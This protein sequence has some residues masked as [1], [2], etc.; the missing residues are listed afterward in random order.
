MAI[1]PD[2]KDWTWV[3]ERPCTECGFD[4]RVV[5]RES[6]PE[7]IRD[8]AAAWQ[9]LLLGSAGADLRR[10]PSDSRWSRLEY[11]CHVRDVFRLFDRRLR[12][13]LESDEPTFPNWDQDAT[14]VADSYREQDPVD[15][16]GALLDAAEILAGDF[17][18]VPAAAWHR[19][20]VR[21][22]GARFSVESLG[23]YLIHDPVHH[24][25]DVACDAGGVGSTS[26][27]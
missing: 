26:A 17:A 23:R 6:L 10:R 8:N 13:M 4:T 18:I 3:L 20:G 15:V 21:S 16:A 11:A 22:D 2:T 24:L 1:V 9:E 25:H 12:L 5:T 19:T 14:A 27:I 7:G